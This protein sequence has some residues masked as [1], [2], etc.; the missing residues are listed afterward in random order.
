MKKTTML[1]LAAGA[2]L[3][4][5]GQRSSDADRQHRAAPMPLDPHPPFGASDIDQTVA[6]TR[7]RMA[8]RAPAPRPVAPRPDATAT[9]PGNSAEN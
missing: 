9:P 4:S 5:C 2:A 3:S 1:I 7:R 6:E 8:P